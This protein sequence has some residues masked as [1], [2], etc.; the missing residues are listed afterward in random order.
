[1]EKKIEYSS[2]NGLSRVAMYWGVPLMAIVFI[3]LLSLVVA[4]IAAMFVGVGGILFGALGFPI[5]L[6]LK[7]ICETD[8][9]AL[10]ITVLEIWCLISRRNAKH[11]GNTYTLSPMQYGRR[12]HVYK[13]YFKKSTSE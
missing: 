2:Y 12:T 5:L 4:V 11:F 10:R 3:V 9:Q 13:R 6:Y 1:M 7:Q 8:D